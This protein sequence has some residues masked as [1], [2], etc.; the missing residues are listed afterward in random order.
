MTEQAKSKI[1]NNIIP[2]VDTV[3]EDLKFKQKFY[4][5]EKK[6]GPGDLPG[7]FFSSISVD[8]CNLPDTTACAFDVESLLIKTQ[9]LVGI[10]NDQVIGIIVDG[11]ITCFGSGTEQNKC[12]EA[13]NNDAPIVLNENN[14][15]A[16]VLV[17]LAIGKIGASN[18]VAVIIA[19]PLV[20]DQS[21]SVEWNGEK[22]QGILLDQ[23]LSGTV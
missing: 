16:N 15:S 12:T 18:S 6:V 8:D 4:E 1:N 3:Q 5:I 11:A 22:P 20:T 14:P 19:C 7:L 10:Q 2:T 13:I 23:E 17:D 21:F 9:G